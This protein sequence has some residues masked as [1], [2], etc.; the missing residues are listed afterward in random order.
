MTDYRIPFNRPSTAGAEADYL[1]ACDGVGS[2]VRQQ[3]IGDERCYLGLVSIYG[4][5]PVRV[6]AAVPWTSRVNRPVTACP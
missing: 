2:A 6:A 5:A 4:Q 3:M 1:V